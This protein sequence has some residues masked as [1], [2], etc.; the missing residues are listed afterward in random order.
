[1]YKFFPNPTYGILYLN[2]SE[3]SGEPVQI[4]IT[5]ITGKTILLQSFQEK[6]IYELDISNTPNG[7][8]IMRIFNKQFFQ[9]DK[10]IKL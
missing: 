1:M 4:K 3:L 2:L 6:G 9:S 10:I 7:V 8:Y 5:D